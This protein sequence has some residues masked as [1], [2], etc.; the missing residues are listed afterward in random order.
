MRAPAQYV[1]AA[2]GT[3]LAYAEQGEG[4]PCLY[5]NPLGSHLERAWDVDAL[6]SFWDWLSARARLIRVD[7]RG[8]GL[9]Q[10]GEVGCSFANLVEDIERVLAQ[11]AVGPIAILAFGPSTLL[12]LAFAHRFPDRVGRLV[13][14][15]PVLS[16]SDLRAGA[17]MDQLGQLIHQNWELFTVL[18]STSVFGADDARAGQQAALLQ[19]SVSADEYLAFWNVLLAA[20]VT[21]LL[22]A[23]AAPTLVILPAESL[24]TRPNSVRRVAAA[25]PNAEVVRMEGK[26][27]ARVTEDRLMVAAIARFLALP[28]DPTPAAVR[29][30]TAVI[31]FADIADST[32]LTEQLG[33]AAFRARARALDESLRRLIRDAGGR[34]IDGK[35]LGDGVL[36]VFPSAR[37]A[38]DAAQH[39]RDSAASAGLPVH[40]G[41]HAGDV[42]D[43]G[44]NVYG[45]A[46]NLAARVAAVAAPGEV[47]VTET[48]RSLARTSAEVAFTSRSAVALK[49]VADPPALFAVVPR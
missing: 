13:L 47:L 27:V 34:S 3:V 37:A 22:P 49:G 32:A 28:A 12:A 11:L 25:L 20:D 16:G 18:S 36:A 43:E 24:A 14:H 10:R 38:I 15:H 8:S 31:M 40:L 7:Y 35:L 4:L 44:G 48:V 5:L 23:I 33:D 26:Y 2:D 46:V 9:S 39:C 19:A 41:L 42:I 45:G 29:E 17:G 6:R 1:T 21:A 30:S